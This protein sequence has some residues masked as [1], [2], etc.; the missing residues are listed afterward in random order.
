MISASLHIHNRLASP[1]FL[2]HVHVSSFAAS[3]LAGVKCRSFAKHH[4]MSWQYIV[5]MRSFSSIGSYL[6]LAILSTKT[7]ECD[8]MPLVRGIQINVISQ[9][10]LKVHPEFSHPDDNLSTTPSE[11]ECESDSNQESPGGRSIISDDGV[12]IFGRYASASVY[13]PSVPGK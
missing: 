8:T 12:D 10:E 3:S 11:A 2:R 5:V 6:H 7:K 9:W 13:I 4:S 1:N